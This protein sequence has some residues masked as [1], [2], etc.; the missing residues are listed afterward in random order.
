MNTIVDIIRKKPFLEYSAAKKPRYDITQ[1]LKEVGFV[2]YEVNYDLNH[3]SYFK[4]ML[5]FL[6]NI[7]NVRQQISKDLKKGKSH[8]IDTLILQYPAYVPFRSFWSKKLKRILNADRVTLVIHD[9]ESLRNESEISQEEIKNLNA[10]SEIVVHTKSM[11]DYLEK[12]GVLRP[13]K[14]LSLFDY[15][16]D[17][18]QDFPENNFLSNTVVFAGNLKKSAFLDKL[19]E[20]LSDIEFYLYGSSDDKEWPSNLKYKGKFH[21][22]NIED[23]EGFWGLVWDGDSIEGCTGDLGEYLK[24]NSPHKASLYI[25]SGKPVIVWDQ[26]AIT[27]FILENKLGI[28]V[29]SLK[30]I[31]QKIKSLSQAELDELKNSVKKWGEKLRNGEMIKEVIALR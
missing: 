28:S 15:R 29:S 24:Y 26:S 5:Y 13:M 10:A 27:P 21:P 18:S 9:I 20:L 30:E 6:R 17:S 23:I 7:N 3:K 16:I 25:A 11:K 31:P 4:R 8:K 12:H 14:I 19:N 1:S 22:N 2:D